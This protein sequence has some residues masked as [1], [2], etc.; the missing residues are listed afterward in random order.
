M[1][2]SA[3]ETLEAPGNPYARQV[4]AL[5]SA[6]LEIVTEDEIR[7]L[8]RALLETAKGGDVPVRLLMATAS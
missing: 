8:A 6:S 3:G 5:R 7:E 4:A 1:A 2:A